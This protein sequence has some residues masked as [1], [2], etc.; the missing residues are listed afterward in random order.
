LVL[1][2]ATLFATVS[3]AAAQHESVL[4]SFA[5]NPVSANGP[6]AG[7]I[8]DASGN[9]YGTTLGGG[10]GTGTV[11]ELTPGA[12]GGWTQKTLYSFGETGSGDGNYPE[13]G[14]IFD[15][16][17]NLYGTT[18]YGGSGC[19]SSSAY[20]GAVF[21][22]M[23]SANGEWTEKIL[24]NFQANGTDGTLP[25]SGLI[26][27]AYGNLYGTALFGG[28]NNLG[29]VYELKPAADGGWKEKVLHSFRD[30]G[31]GQNPQAGLILDTSGNLYG[32]TTGDGPFANGIVFE[33]TPA[34]SGG[35]KYKVLHSFGTD[36]DG[37]FILNGLVADPVGNLFGTTHNGG[38]QGVGMVFELSPQA[39]GLWTTRILH[40]FVLGGTD[41]LSPSAGVIM[42]SAGNLYGTTEG[43]GAHNFGTVFE[44]SPTA[45]GPWTERILHS[46]HGA[47]GSLPSSLLIIDALGHLYGTTFLGGAYFGGE[48][49]EIIP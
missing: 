12:A 29:I 37:G 4:Y 39:G 5:G 36:S 3:R 6:L 25:Q 15:A 40:N 24:H 26:L 34:A 18:A 8:F 1:L 2:A 43:G 27:D 46:F 45:G 17:G 9:L 10:N 47:D 41:G 11:F 30:N 31:D 48:V 23:P 44:L 28:T 19:N 49:F 21:E 33:L 22:L 7:L 42:D 14:L 16:T 20:C 32:T 38:S 35:W 13:A